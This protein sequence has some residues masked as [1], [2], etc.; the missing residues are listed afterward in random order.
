M[1]QK[2]KMV[3]PISLGLD[4]E[5]EGPVETVHGRDKYI[6]SNQ[7]LTSEPARI[8]SCTLNRELTEVMA[9]AR[10]GI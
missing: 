9:K 2:P 6:V 8:R 4:S 1:S 10:C 7:D 5:S 3:N